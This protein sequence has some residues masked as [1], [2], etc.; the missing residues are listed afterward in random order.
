MRN[1]AT[2]QPRNPQIVNA[3][4]A[5][6]ALREH[7]S[8]L[9]VEFF[10]AGESEMSA[11]V[12]QVFEAL[13][14]AVL[15]IYHSLQG[16]DAELPLRGFQIKAFAVLHSTFEE[17]LW[18]DTDT[19][20]ASNMTSAFDS[21]IYQEHGS[22]F[23]QDWSCDPHWL[24][25]DFMAAYGVR[26][27]EGEREFEAGQFLLSKRRAWVPLLI[28][29]HMT[30]HFDHFYR[31]L[32]GD[33]DTWRLAFKIAGVDVGLAP[34]A[35]DALGADD[36]S[37]RQCG[38]TMLHKNEAG[39]VFT[40]HRTL[41]TLPSTPTPL[42]PYLREL[43]DSMLEKAASPSG[44]RL[45]HWKTS[46]GMQRLVPRLNDSAP[47]WRVEKQEVD[48][49]GN[50]HWCLYMDADTHVRIQEVDKKLHDLESS[51]RGYMRDL[52][53]LEVMGTLGA[54]VVT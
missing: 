45:W 30:R 39:N 15:D 28:V 6:R 37:G 16:A 12:V 33:K 2:P 50:L 48:H 18:L 46:T 1:P 51:L 9:P 23:W 43:S 21:V 49:Y 24:S 31:R 47:G 35:P 3:Y 20:P 13:G 36:P 29:L 40:L 7:G 44:A 27:Q 11:E 54:S 32:Y 42:P 8:E 53:A 17:V 38:N 4:C 22:L 10:Y 14:V 25:P 26:M 52:A 5:L 34:L 41:Q 19:V